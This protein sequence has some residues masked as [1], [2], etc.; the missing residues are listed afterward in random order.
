MIGDCLSVF[1]VVE[2]GSIQLVAASFDLR[3]G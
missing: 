2:A 1:A 3:S